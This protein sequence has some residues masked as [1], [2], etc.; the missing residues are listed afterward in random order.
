M[1][2]WSDDDYELIFRAY[3]PTETEAPLAEEC[4]RLGL[5]LGRSAGAVLAQWNDGRSLVL[6]HANDA[7]GPLRDYFLRRGWL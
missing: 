5:A 3:P 6:G 4:N 1:D 2:G 7:S